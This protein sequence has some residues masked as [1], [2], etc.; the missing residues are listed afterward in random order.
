M[1]YL[2]LNPGYGNLFD[3]VLDQASYTQVLNADS[4]TGKSF[5]SCGRRA[6]T[7]PT[8]MSEIWLRCDYRPYGNSGLFEVDIRSAS[9]FHCVYHSNGSN[10]I[11]LYL[12]SRN[13]SSYYFGSRWQR[14][15]MHL[16]SDL[17][18]GV[19]EV[20]EDED[21]KYSFT[22]NVGNGEGITDCLFT[23]THSDKNISQIIISDSQINWTENVIIIPTTLSSTMTNNGDGTYSATSSGEYVNQT[24]DSASL[25][26]ICSANTVITGLC[27]AGRPAYSDGVGIDTM[28]AMADNT[29]VGECQ[30]SSSSAKSIFFGDRVNKPIGTI[31]GTYG[32]K[33]K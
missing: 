15:L 32:W 31:S 16:K 26:N 29:V 25:R 12:N 10:T 19:F 17:T 8:P 30:L 9:W 23:S 2:Y 24:I 11:S 14:F 33:A 13:V 3:S 4:E 22:G 27:I 7:F 20:W 5:H 6:V 21:L 1:S 18:N 28:Q